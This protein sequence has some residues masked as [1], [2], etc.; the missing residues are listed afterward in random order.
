MPPFEFHRARVARSLTVTVL[1]LLAGSAFASPPD[2]RYDHARHADHSANCNDC[3]RLEA[4][5]QWQQRVRVAKGGGTHAA[6]TKCHEKEWASFDPR[7]GSALCGSCHDLSAARP[8]FAKIHYP[9]YR[10]GEE[11]QFR[12]SKF[13]H[14]DHL[15][16]GNRGCSQCHAMETAGM[17]GALDFKAIG[18]ETCGNQICHGE[19]VA[20]LMSDCRACHELGPRPAASALEASLRVDVGFAHDKHQQLAKDA[21]CGDCHTN[22]AVGAGVRIPRPPMISCERCHDGTKAFSA[23]GTQC[24]KCHAGKDELTVAFKEPESP[25]VYAH[26]LHN[27][28]GVPL[29]CDQCHPSAA[30]GRIEFPVPNKEHKPCAS[31]HAAE[32]RQQNS[33]ICLSCHEHNQPWRPNP[34]R[35][36]FRGGTEF[37]VVLEHKAHAKVACDTCHAEQAGKPVASAAPG[38]LAPSHQLCAGCHESLQKPLMTSCGD[39]HSLEAARTAAAQRAAGWSVRAM[40]S[41]DRHRDREQRAGPEC[42]SCHVGTG[43]SEGPPPHPQKSGCE[44]CHASG[45]TAFSVTGFGCHRCHGAAEPPPPKP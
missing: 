31:C 13:S 26:A 27:D 36:S 24:A 11:S 2:G 45:K 15:R 37:A 21:Q 3:H 38:L 14:A 43:V 40:F 5:T 22:V 33:A 35:T 30:N 18:H 29:T 20:P 42:L 44:T 12:L 16:D 4:A 32:F 10:R 25:A 6:C 9:P 7:K 19:R 8:N 23:L 39:C 28:K 17:P 1:G 41:H 34:T